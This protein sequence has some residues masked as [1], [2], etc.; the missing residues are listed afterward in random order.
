MKDQEST[1][2]P[3]KKDDGL[4]GGICGRKD[5]VGRSGVYPMSGPHP[6]GAAEV[7][8]QAAWGQGER[9][10]PGYED[11]GSSELSYEGGQVLGGYES[12]GGSLAVR[13]GQGGIMQLTSSAFRHEGS[14]PKQYTCEGQNISPELAWSG[15]PA[16]TKSYVLIMHDPDAPRANGFTHWVLYNIPGSLDRIPENLSKEPNA[17]GVGTQGRNDS[18]SIGYMGP[19]PPSGT[20]RYFTRLYALRSHIELKPGAT[21]HEVLE[22]I[23]GHVIEETE[24][25]GTYA[26]S[27][28]KVA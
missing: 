12:R 25:M 28:Q 13:P 6:P 16:E 1:I 18:G 14:I 11:H 19:C 10:A 26:K 17:S 15:A 23:Q 4:P 3:K 21:Q 20:H 7:R 2:D 22:A 5:E 9:G 27:G 8:S 24:L